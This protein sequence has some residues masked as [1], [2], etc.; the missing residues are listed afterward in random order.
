MTRR[1]RTMQS[2]TVGFLNNTD[3]LYDQKLCVFQRKKNKSLLLNNFRKIENFQASKETWNKLK[4][5]ESVKKHDFRCKYLDFFLNFGY[6][7]LNIILSPGS[8]KL[9]FEKFFF[10]NCRS[11]IPTSR[12]YQESKSY[13][14]SMI[15]QLT[16][17]Q[18]IQVSILPFASQSAIF[19]LYKSTPMKNSWFCTSP[20][21][22]DGLKKLKTKKMLR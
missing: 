22:L 8:K 15:K 17:L 13:Q 10:G 6:H 9:Q 18:K 5:W 14:T 3:F 21:K 7:F 2:R 4:V 16:F 12:K 20:H 19:Y 11:V 1:L